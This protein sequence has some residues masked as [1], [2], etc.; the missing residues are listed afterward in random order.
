MNKNRVLPEAAPAVG[1]TYASKLQAWRRGNLPIDRVLSPPELPE[2]GIRS[3]PGFL[4]PVVFEEAASMQ[5]PVIAPAGTVFVGA[6]SYM[7]DGGYMRSRIAV[8]RYCSIGRRV[9]IA[10]G[11]HDM[12][13]LSTSPTLR[14][15]SGAAYDEAQ[16]ERL[17]VRRQPGAMTFIGHDVWIGDGAV[18]MPGVTVGNGAV[19]GA[20]SVV[21][22][23]VTDYTVVA[24]V[25]AR[26][27]R[28]RFPDTIASELLRLTWW[29][30]PLETL[31]ALHLNNVFEFIEQ[32]AALGE[33]GRHNFLTY[34]MAPK[35]A[36][37]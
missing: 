11:M 2:V 8:G 20:N 35:P 3:R 14:L 15:R 22:R 17:K 16:L 7:N 12:H 36:A 4:Q 23:D 34:A 13:S 27:I 31:K 26:T 10:A 29:D 1:S 18:I 28:Q 24:G 9:T 30:W 25:P 33:P 6:H 21:T 32:A 37:G 5:S 19:I